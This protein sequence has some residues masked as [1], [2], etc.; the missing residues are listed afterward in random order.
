MNELDKNQNTTLFRNTFLTIL[1]ECT[2]GILKSDFKGNPLITISGY[3]Y[4]AKNANNK[5]YK[6]RPR[7]YKKQ[8]RA[9]AC[10]GVHK[11]LKRTI[12]DRG[13]RIKRATT[14]IL[15]YMRTH[16]FLASHPCAHITQ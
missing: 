4:I 2:I 6:I 10:V 5:I 11:K 12:Y 14:N 7:T 15:L 13:K 16:S 1:A 8:S 3:L 9:H